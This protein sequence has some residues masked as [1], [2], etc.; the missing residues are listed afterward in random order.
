MTSFD[1]HPHAREQHE[2]TYVPADSDNDRVSYHLCECKALFKYEETDI[3]TRTGE[4]TEV[5]DSDAISIAKAYV[6]ERLDY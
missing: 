4:W 1:M 2:M 3:V 5:T 6:A